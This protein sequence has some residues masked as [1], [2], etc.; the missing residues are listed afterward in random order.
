MSKLWTLI[1]IVIGVTA[2]SALL[3]WM[4]FRLAR[5][6]D[7]IGQEPRYRRRWLLYGAAVYAFGIVAGVSQVFS[8]DAPPTALLFV[9]I[10]ILIVWVC[11][12]AAKLGEVSPD[13]RGKG[14]S[15]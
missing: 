6:M 8:G 7:T 4:A 15:P 11:L 2:A 13:P 5:H 3:G 14:S 10:P 9:P 1:S 12:R